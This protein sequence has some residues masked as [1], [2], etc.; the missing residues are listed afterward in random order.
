[1][2]YT[3]DAEQYRVYRAFKYMYESRPSDYPSTRGVASRASVKFDVA[4][5]HLDYMRTVGII[6]DSRVYLPRYMEDGGKISCGVIIFNPPKLPVLRIPGDLSKVEQTVF[7]AARSLAPWGGRIKYEEI[8]GKS[9]VP[10]DQ[11][12][13][14]V[15]SL[16]QR[17]I[18]IWIKPRQIA[19]KYETPAIL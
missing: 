7:D 3:L 5:M 2:K 19:C 10:W 11:F 17:R 4:D 1:M 16:G 9:R 14:A 13:E 12:K 6:D 8:Q 18:W 15:E